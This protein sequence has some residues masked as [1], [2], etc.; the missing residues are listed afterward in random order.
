MYG[1][2]S[3][4]RQGSVRVRKQQDRSSKTG[5]PIGLQLFSSSGGATLLFLQAE[6]PSIWAGAVPFAGQ[7]KA[8]FQGTHCMLLIEHSPYERITKRLARYA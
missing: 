1:M 6:A 7:S 5:L 3:L 8:H 4:A 2:G